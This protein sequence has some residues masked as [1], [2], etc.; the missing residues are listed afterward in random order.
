MGGPRGQVVQQGQLDMCNKF[1]FNWTY[2]VGIMT[3]NYSAQHLTNW[4]DIYTSAEAQGS[5]NCVSVHKCDTCTFL[6]QFEQMICA[7]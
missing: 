2:R 1:H 5:I 3:F 6:I 7:I 4:G